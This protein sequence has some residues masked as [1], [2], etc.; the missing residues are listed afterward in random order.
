M[1]REILLTRQQLPSDELKRQYMMNDNYINDN[2]INGI[3]IL[4]NEQFVPYEFT[5]ASNDYT[6]WCFVLSS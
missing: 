6:L 5:P 1:I 2:Y 3:K 4:R